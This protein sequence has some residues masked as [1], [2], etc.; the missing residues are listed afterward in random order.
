[1]K[2]PLTPGR[3]QPCRT[4]KTQAGLQVTGERLARQASAVSTNTPSLKYMPFDLA[5]T[6]LG[7]SETTIRIW[8][9]KC[10]L[11]GY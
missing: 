2:W 9:E 7:T 10:R 5:S 8:K 1:M 6:F 11:R 3:S 4:K